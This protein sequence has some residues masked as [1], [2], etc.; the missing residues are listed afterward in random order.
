MKAVVLL[1]IVLAVTSCRSKKVAQC[2]VAVETVEVAESNVTVDV[3]ELINDSCEVEIDSPL[4]EILRPD[5][6]VVVMKA[7]KISARKKVETKTAVTAT[8]VTSDSTA[9]CAHVVAKTVS[10]RR[11]CIFKPWM[12]AVAVVGLIIIVVIIKKVSRYGKYV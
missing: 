10:E 4:V 5:S 9:Q 7:R 1:C 2:D 11:T 12:L 6:V 8:Q 3:R